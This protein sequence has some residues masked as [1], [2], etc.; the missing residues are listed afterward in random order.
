MSNCATSCA[1]EDLQEG[2]EI[3]CKSSPILTSMQAPYK[4]ETKGGLYTARTKRPLILQHCTGLSGASHEFKFLA[5]PD[6][7]NLYNVN[8]HMFSL[9]EN[10]QVHPAKSRRAHYQY[11]DSTADAAAAAGAA[12]VPA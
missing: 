8:G 2:M 12:N 6:P 3:I 4:V 5:V 11:G 9:S 7:Q 1:R 10:L